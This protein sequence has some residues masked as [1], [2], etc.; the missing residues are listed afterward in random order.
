MV[1]IVSEHSTCRAFYHATCR[2]HRISSRV[3]TA[4]RY[5]SLGSNPTYQVYRNSKVVGDYPGCCA[6]AA[7]TEAILKV[8]PDAE[9][10]HG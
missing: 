1:G 10:D 8:E 7:K 2:T 4:Y 3:Y 9:D 6:Y 5:S